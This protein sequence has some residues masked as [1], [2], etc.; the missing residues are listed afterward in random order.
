MSVQRYRVWFRKGE[1][2]RHISHLDVLRFWERAIRRADLPL[3]YSQGFTPHPRIAFAAPLP[4][5]FVSESEVMEVSLDERVDAVEFRS[6][7][8]G[9]TS[10]DLEVVDVAEV[11]LNGAAPQA[12][13][14]WA[15]Y[16][17]QLC[18]FSLEDA[19]GRVD[20]FLA[21]PG[22]AWTD[23]KKEKSRTYDLRAAVN[24]LRASATNG[25]VCLAMR[26]QADQ[27][28]TA[29]PEHLVE[30]LFPGAEPDLVARTG[31]VLDEPS[32]AH[33]AWRRRG[34]FEQ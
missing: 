33:E 2:V 5:G 6:R 28:V 3:S 29:R 9:E 27:E 12:L 4:L 14:L 13:L 19:R 31:V 10:E 24:S 21:L 22:L 7:L 32:P 17:V 26:L 15:D 8:A 11:P 1:R 34:R 25:G 18:G 20:H 30:A 23:E 16:A